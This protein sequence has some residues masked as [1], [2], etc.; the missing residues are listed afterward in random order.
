M[1]RPASHGQGARRVKNLGYGQANGQAKWGRWLLLILI[2]QLQWWLAAP[3]WRALGKQAKVSLH[4]NMRLDSSVR[5]SQ[6]LCLGRT[7]KLSFIQRP[8]TCLVNR[9]ECH[10]LECSPIWLV[11]SGQISTLAIEN[12]QTKAK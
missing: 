4:N 12:S 1:Q 10:Q 5:R 7:K 8:N 3:R 9:F 6:R 2:Y 11:P